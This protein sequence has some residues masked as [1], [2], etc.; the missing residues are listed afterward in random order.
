[1][2]E[3]EILLGVTSV[4][5]CVVH[6]R[7]ATGAH[8]WTWGAGL[9]SA[10]CPCAVADRFVVVSEF[11]SGPW[12]SAADVVVAAERDT[13]FAASSIVDRLG[14]LPGC[15]LVFV[16]LAGGG[17]VLGRREGDVVMPRARL[18]PA[19]VYAWLACR[20]EGT[21]PQAVFRPGPG[22]PAHE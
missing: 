4:T 18:C 14:R 12:L 9:V 13:A 3:H 1:M 15:A 7:P 6:S 2:C 16:P 8:V 17:A 11:A 21:S 22:R 10:P 19:C 5:R 20:A